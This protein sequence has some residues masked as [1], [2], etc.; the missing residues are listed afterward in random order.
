MQQSPSIRKSQFHVPKR[1]VRVR[2]ELAGG[3][4]FSGSFYA[5]QLNSTGGPGRVSDRLN[6]DSEPFIPL[7]VEDNHVLVRKSVIAIVQLEDEPWEAP[8]QTSKTTE[9]NLRVK[10]TNGN[11]TRGRIVAVLP[12]GR[13]RALDYLNDHPGGFFAMAS[14]ERRVTLVNVAHIE[15]VTEFTPES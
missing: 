9:L 1:R 4:V 3:V 5:D 11:S 7:A 14:G 10:L 15:S 6:D 2:L 13:S 8:H 12:Q